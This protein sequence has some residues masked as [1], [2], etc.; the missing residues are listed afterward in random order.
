[1]RAASYWL[2]Q[3]LAFAGVTHDI[4]SPADRLSWRQTALFL[5]KLSLTWCSVFLSHPASLFVLSS[6]MKLKRWKLFEPYRHRHKGCFKMNV[7]YSTVKCAFTAIL[8]ENSLRTWTRRNVT[9]RHVLK[10]FFFCVVQSHADQWWLTN[11]KLL[12]VSQAHCCIS[13]ELTA[14]ECSTV[15]KL[16]RWI[17]SSQFSADHEGHHVVLVTLND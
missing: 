16:C 8:W 6:S 10:F 11:Y 12:K 17:E 2:E 4:M 5:G 3:F 1:M 7:R 15:L 9:P 13:L 14:H